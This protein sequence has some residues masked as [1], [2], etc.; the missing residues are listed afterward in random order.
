MVYSNMLILEV[1]VSHLAQR[2]LDIFE[3]NAQLEDRFL[4][5]LWLLAASAFE[6][7][8]E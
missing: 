2:F 3:L 1:N 8:F 6:L 4:A 5:L 7:V